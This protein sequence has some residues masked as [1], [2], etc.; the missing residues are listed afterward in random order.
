MAKQP[1]PAG[2]GAAKRLGKTTLG[3]AAS[4]AFSGAPAFSP[5]KRDRRGVDASF[6]A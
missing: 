1:F 2:G 5:L 3:P 4:K 6:L